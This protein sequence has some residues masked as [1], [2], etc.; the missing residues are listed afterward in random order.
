MNEWNV[1]G[2]I[3]YLKELKGEFAASVKIEGI[4]KREDGSFSSQ[5][6]E[7]GCL[8]Q[9]RVWTESQKLGIKV[10]SKV[11]LSGHLETWKTSSKS[12]KVMFIA[13]DILEVK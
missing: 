11:K 9:R 10:N 13:D 7:V 4:A 8:L 1:T 5:I 6:L 2:R 12:G 3:F